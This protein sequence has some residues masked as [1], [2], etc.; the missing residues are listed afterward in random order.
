MLLLDI[1]ELS[2]HRL[3]GCNGNAVE[4]LEELAK[5]NFIEAHERHGFPDW[6]FAWKFYG[7]VPYTVGY[8]WK[9]VNILP[10]DKVKNVFPESEAPPRFQSGDDP[11]M[12]DEIARR[13]W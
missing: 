6:I 10:P 4:Y 9:M 11:W 2:L 12:D 8:S 7:H 1:T 5:L 13:D 3:T